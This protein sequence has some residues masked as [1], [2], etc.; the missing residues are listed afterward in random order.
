MILFLLHDEH[1]NVKSAAIGEQS[2]RLRLTLRPERDEA[3]T[4]VRVSRDE[5]AAFQRNPR[6][7]VEDFIV[8]TAA[9]NFLRNTA[10]PMLSCTVQWNI[11]SNPFHAILQEP[12][13]FI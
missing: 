8:E 3:M 11:Y 13:K 6:G 4:E 5:I 7:I 1:G 12:S 2:I 10:R 9:R